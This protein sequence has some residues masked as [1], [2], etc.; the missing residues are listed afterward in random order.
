MS[1]WF[2]LGDFV[3]RVSSGA[4]AGLGEIVETVRTAFAGDAE[5]RRRVAFSVAM[6]ALSAKMARADGVVTRD[7]VKAFH[8][9]FAV[10]G[11][12]MDNV[13]R[14]YDLAK[15]DTAGF[16]AYAGRMA[17]LCGSGETNCA[18]LED[19]LEGLFHIAKADGMVHERE[20]GFL[21][22]VAE[23]F[24]IEEGHFRSMLARHAVAGQHDPYLVLGVERGASRDDIRKVYR[25][26]VSQNHPDRMI[27]RGVPPEFVAIAT[28]RVARINAA[29]EAIE[30]GMRPR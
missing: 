21:R 8:D 19:I 26:L 24:E 16:E 30:R 5:T 18:M 12:E 11:E 15:R 2:R 4:R 20:V 13:R 23:I 10:P 9:I 29:Y 14:L 25:R 17:S 27:A 3:Q 22:R 28:D 7:E 1:I 6:I